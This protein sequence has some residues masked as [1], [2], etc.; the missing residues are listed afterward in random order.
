MAG[1]IPPVPHEPLAEGVQWRNWLTRV[2][3][4]RFSFKEIDAQPPTTV[5]SAG[6]MG[7]IRVTATHVYF[8]IA[9]DTWR[10]IALSTW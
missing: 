4:S 9:K 3:T 7:E 1:L 2:Y 6:Q 5:A 10:R 8:C